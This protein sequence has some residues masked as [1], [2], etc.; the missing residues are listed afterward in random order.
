MKNL[1]NEKIKAMHEK[2]KKVTR[3]ALQ[4]VFM[5]IE[6]FFPEVVTEANNPYFTDVQRIT[7]KKSYLTNPVYMQN[8]IIYVASMLSDSILD[9]LDI[10]LILY[11]KVS[12]ID[13]SHC[14]SANSDFLVVTF[15]YL[16]DNKIENYRIAI[17]C[18]VKNDY[19]YFN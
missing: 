13:I 9:D 8:I 11:C 1:S 14:N 18:R 15:E 12:A 3:E 16:N 4:N 7:C 2:N 19:I 5:T 17:K 10:K 6:D